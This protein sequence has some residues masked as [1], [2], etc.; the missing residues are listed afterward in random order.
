MTTKIDHH[1]AVRQ[2]SGA[3]TGMTPPD[4]E[5]PERSSGRRQFSA[6]YKA[7][8]LTEYDALDRSARGALLRREGL[9]SSLISTWRQQRDLGAHEALGRPAGRRPADPRDREIA[10]LKR[11]NERL[12]ADLDKQRRVVEIQGKLSAL[13]EQL[14]T[15][16]TAENGERR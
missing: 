1:V 8:V 3:M 13:L 2:D 12:A 10:R 16:S 6:K 7:R 11:E 4:P 9:Y 15:D 5:V 14:A